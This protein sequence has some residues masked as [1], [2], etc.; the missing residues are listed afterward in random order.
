MIS[1]ERPQANFVYQ[2]NTYAFDIRSAIPSSEYVWLNRND[3]ITNPIIKYD[4]EDEYIKFDSNAIQSFIS[5]LNDHTI[6]PLISIDTVFTLNALSLKFVTKSLQSHID[7]YINMNH[8]ELLPI[9]L[10]KKTLTSDDENKISKF[11]IEYIESEQL[12]SLSLTSIGR[13]LS[14]YRINQKNKDDEDENKLQKE[15][16]IMNFIFLCLNKY[17]SDASFLFNYIDFQTVGEECL[18]II[19]EKYKSIINFQYLNN[20]ILLHSIFN[21]KFENNV[22]KNDENQCIK[23]DLPQNEEEN[24]K[25][26]VNQEQNQEEIEFNDNLNKLRHNKVRSI[27]V[28][29]GITTIKTCYFKNTDI[30]NV[31]LPETI[32]SIEDESFEYCQSLI[33]LTIN[34]Q[35]LKSIP[36]YSFYSCLKLEKINLPNSLKSIGAYAFCGCSLKTIDLP[37]SLKTIGKYAFC[38]CEKL[39]SIVIPESVS[40]INEHTFSSCIKLLSVKLPSSL[41]YIGNHAFC[42]CKSLKSVYIPD[43][44]SSIESYTFCNCYELQDVR[45]PSNITS[46]GDYAFHDCWKLSDF[47]M[48]AVTYIGTLA[49]YNCIGLR[50]V[51]LP[52]VKHI[53][54]GAFILC[55]FPDGC[56]IP[57]ISDIGEKAFGSNVQ[58]TIIYYE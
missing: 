48:K 27:I 14:L 28:P 10:N 22:N 52:L 21:Y 35:I 29:N 2:K 31:T 37:N 43:S 12:L 38:G 47:E 6:I 53:G 13:I 15:R 8:I 45:I 7:N 58:K 54:S 40:V 1:E 9:I 17:S 24:K 26:A 51:E 50:K 39:E 49:F 33:E 46:V 41:T 4:E 57:P 5:Y 42:N 18:N 23:S 32:D 44:I 34:S 56:K 16:K 11:L 30:E 3:L 36:K 25:D 20:D 55:T 19:N